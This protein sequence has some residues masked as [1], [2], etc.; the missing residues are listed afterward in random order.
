MCI[1]HSMTKG[2]DIIHQP[3]IAT[4]PFISLLITVRKE[5]KKIHFFTQHNFFF[6]VIHGWLMHH[7]ADFKSPF[8][9]IERRKK[10]SESTASTSR[11]ERKHY[12][13]QPFCTRVT[14]TT[15]AF[16]LSWNA[17]DFSLP[18]NYCHGRLWLWWNGRKWNIICHVVYR[19]IY[20]ESNIYYISCETACMTHVDMRITVLY[21]SYPHLVYLHI[22]LFE[23]LAISLCVTPKTSHL[24][25]I[26]PVEIHFQAW[27]EIFTSSLFI[28]LQRTPKRFCNNKT[29]NTCCANS[30][31]QLSFK[32]TLY[33]R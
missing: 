33:I 28:I 8:S 6:V 30:V 13:F 10:R 12:N 9:R 21:T 18:E 22:Y 16:F 27:T 11:R 5:E 2:N 20:Y 4:M 32:D 1:W 23:H 25:W 7:H 17:N 3:L 29:S 15:R 19:H 31:K 14:I 26:L 24:P